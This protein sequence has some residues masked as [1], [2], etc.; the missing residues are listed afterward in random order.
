[1]MFGTWNLCI[2]DGGSQKHITHP[3][4]DIYQERKSARRNAARVKVN[5]KFG[6]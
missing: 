3:S 6:D 1:M 2:L 4:Y 5:A